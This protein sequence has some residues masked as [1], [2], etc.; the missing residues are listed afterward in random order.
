MPIYCP[1]CGASNR[2]TARFCAK[3]S[4]PLVPT[5]PRSTPGRACPSCGTANSSQAR[6]CK[7]CGQP[8]LV[9]AP[10]PPGAAATGMLPANSMLAGRY[11]ILQRVGQG[12]MGAVYKAVDTR[13]H[14]RLCAV[15]EMSSAGLSNV[16]RQLARANFEREAKMLASLNHPNLPR[17]TDYFSESGRHYMVMEFIEG[18]PL[19]EHISQTGQAM[20]EAEVRSVAGQLCDVL[21]YLHSQQPPVIFRDMKPGNVM[22]QPYGRVKLIDFGIVRFFKYGKAHDTQFLGTPGFAAPEAYGHTQTDARSDIYSLGM[23]LYCLLTAKD[24]PQH[25]S[26]FDLCAELA[27]YASP[28]LCQAIL[29][30]LELRPENRWQT[31]TEM[32]QAMGGAG[33][34]PRPPG[35]TPM[36]APGG[37]RGATQRLTQSIARQVQQMS[38]AQLAATA[39][40]LVV[41][42]GLITWLVGP[43]IRANLPWLWRFLPIYYAAGPFAYAVSHRKG[44]VALVHTPLHVVVA[45]LTWNWINLGHYLLTGLAG[46]AGMEAVLSFLGGAKPSVWYYVAAAAVGITLAMGVATLLP[47]GYFDVVQIGGAGLA[48]AIAYAAGEAVWGVR[49]G[50]QTS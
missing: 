15:K 48:G 17:V 46:A 7:G 14:Q 24:P 43:W 26:G 44:A 8:L 33:A 29:K 12:G 20:S 25:L 49:Q 35:P 11:L 45:A 39:L 42:I 4:G 50:V 30:A 13:L 37:I 6:F 16:E 41:G 19:H 28:E 18:Y 2:D 34:V 32:R 27:G 21:H 22:L 10:P 23:T 47:G 38:N 36:P 40:A 3:C 5:G 1:K 31:T 9:S